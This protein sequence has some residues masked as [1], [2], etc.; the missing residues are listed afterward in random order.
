MINK[1]QKA[2]EYAA[3]PE[4]ATFHSMTIEFRG[5]NSVYTLALGPDGWS[6]SC[7][8]FQNYGICPHIMAMEKLFKPMLKRDPLPYAPGQNIV[9]DV[10]KA[11]RYS[12]EQERIRFIEFS[13]V[14]R[15]DNKDHQVT[16]QRGQWSSTS[17]F[18]KTHGVCPYT[19]AMER[20]LK[21]MVEPIHLPTA[22]E[23]E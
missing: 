5:D 18:F 7:P 10:K 15:G 4:R 21:G 13:A 8:G 22:L 23:A 20:I 3:E 12:E 14:F 1:I 17:T 9:S 19:M 2:R 16:Y 11:H 6:C